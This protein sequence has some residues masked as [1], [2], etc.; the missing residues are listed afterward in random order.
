MRRLVISIVTAVVLLVL[1]IVLFTFV[2]RPYETVLL[3]RFG[4]LIPE[5]QQV[6]LAYNWYLKMPS[7][8]VVRVD[9]RLHLYQGALQE[10]ITQR[11]EPIGVQT[12]AAWRIIDPVKFYKQTSG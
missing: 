4:N 2:R 6:R 8:G 10:V 9:Q 12:Y 11:A 7:D 5:S 3:D 1:F